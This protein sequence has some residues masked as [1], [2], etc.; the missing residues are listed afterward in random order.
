[1]AKCTNLHYG[2][3]KTKVTVVGSALDMQYYQDVSPWTLDGERVKVTEDNDH[4][5]HIVSGICQEDKN[6]DA[7]IDKGRKNLNAC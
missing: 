1:M 3:S 6:V 4:L 2:A 7:R 5:G